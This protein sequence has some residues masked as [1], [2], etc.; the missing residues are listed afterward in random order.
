LLPKGEKILWEGAPVELKVFSL[1]DRKFALISGGTLV[2]FI[3]VE[4]LG[5]RLGSSF[6][7]LG[8]GPLILLSLYVFVGRRWLKVMQHRT[9]HYLITNKRLIIIEGDEVTTRKLTA[10]GEIRLETV[11]NNV[12]NIYIDSPD[13]TPLS[14]LFVEDFERVFAALTKIQAKSKPKKRRRKIVKKS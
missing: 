7:Q 3:A 13:S 2:L 11:E 8:L 4:L 5:I 6:I 9:T 12:G 1:E 10:L 14:L